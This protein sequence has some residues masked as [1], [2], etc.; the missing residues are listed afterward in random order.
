MYWAATRLQYCLV[1]TLWWAE[2]AF[3]PI[4]YAMLQSVYLY[5]VSLCYT[6]E[7]IE[8]IDLVFSQY[9]HFVFTFSLTKFYK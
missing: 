3:I 2:A 4:Q 1:T 7:K 9:W 8:E 5:A 6:F